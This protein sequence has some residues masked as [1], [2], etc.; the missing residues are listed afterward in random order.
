[1]KVAI[2]ASH[3]LK[4]KNLAK[5]AEN[6]LETV[7]VEQADVIVAFGGDGFML[8]SLKKYQKYKIKKKH[9]N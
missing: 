2:L 3:K 8:A 9:K 6:F 5:I 4:A 1:M 7:P